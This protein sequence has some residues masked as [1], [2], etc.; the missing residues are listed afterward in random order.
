[1]RILFYARGFESVG[2]EYLSAV[3][4]DR[5]HQ[6]GLLFDPG[7]DDNSYAKLPFLRGLNRYGRLMRKAREFRPDLVG[8]SCLT[9]LF[10]HVSRMAAALKKE[11][12]V[13]IIMGGPHPSAIPEY[14]LDNTDVDMVCIGEGEEALC[15]VADR[16]SRQEPVDDVRNIWLKRNGKII[17]NPV[18]PLLEDL[19]LLPLPDKDLFHR[20]GVFRHGV[21]VVTSRGCSFNCS[22]CIHPFYKGLY[23]EHGYK[24]RRRSVDNVMAELHKYCIKYKAR[25]FLFEDDDFAADNEWVEEFSERYHREINLPFYC[26]TNPN[27]ISEK[28]AGQLKRA[29]CYQLF[30][31]VDTGNETLRREVLNRK[32]SNESLKRAARTIK[33]AGIRLHTTAMF[34][35]PGESPTEMME[36]LHF[37]Q[38]LAPDTVSTYTFYPYPGTKLAEYAKE[39]GLVSA[40]AEKDIHEGKNS[41]HYMSVLDHPHKKIAYSFI[42]ALPIYVKAPDLLKP[43]LA[44]LALNERFHRLTPLLYYLFIPITYPTFGVVRIKAMLYLLYRSIVPVKEIQE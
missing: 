36:T 29:G 41:L 33:E 40:G 10:P 28:K 16:M 13:P 39:N 43:L 6:V 42:N 7:F 34:G 35:L 4:K 24:I 38:E 27:Q 23:K 26:L 44:K 15:E 12:G 1:M 37:I 2:I 31:G 30:M 25:F 11:L 17:R 14:V 5:G 32:H 18:R 20:V 3:L 8:F 9:N 19:D 22:Y 21:M